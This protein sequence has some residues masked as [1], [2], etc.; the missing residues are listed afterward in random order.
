MERGGNP[1][2]RPGERSVSDSSEYLERP[3]RLGGTPQSLQ[4]ELRGGVKKERKNTVAGE[5]IKE[6]VHTRLEHTEHPLHT[7][8][9]T[10]TIR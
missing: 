6:T 2:Y 3:P 9:R 4:H 8:H 1:V 5:K 7:H 10:T